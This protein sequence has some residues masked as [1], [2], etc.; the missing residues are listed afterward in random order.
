MFTGDFDTDSIAFLSS[1]RV[2][3]FH[4][5]VRKLTVNKLT[6]ERARKM[7]LAETSAAIDINVNLFEDRFMGSRN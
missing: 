1:A 2:F 7:L 3:L 6:L 4:L 5:L